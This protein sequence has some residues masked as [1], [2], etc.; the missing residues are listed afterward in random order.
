MNAFVG[1]GVMLAAGPFSAGAA[2]GDPLLKTADER[3]ATNRKASARIKVVDAK[4]NPV[5]GVTVKVEQNRHAFLF[6]CNAFRFYYHPDDRDSTYA[7]RFSAL[8]N[9]ATLPFYWELYEPRT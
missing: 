6:G 4:G 1:L 3:I 2:E 5:P 9:Y 7:A 8:F